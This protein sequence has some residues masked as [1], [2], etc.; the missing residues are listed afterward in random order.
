MSD[1][2][3]SDGSSDLAQRVDKFVDH[4]FAKMLHEAI[5]TRASSRVM[6]GVLEVLFSQL[7]LRR[8]TDSELLSLWLDQYDDADGTVIPP[9]FT[10]L[11]MVLHWDYFGGELFPDGRWSTKEWL[12]NGGATQ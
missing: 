7:L 2:P 3:I 10:G 12:Q 4:L 9:M 1:D 5:L 8:P 11:P 6:D